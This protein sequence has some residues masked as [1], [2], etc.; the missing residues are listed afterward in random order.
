MSLRKTLILAVATAALAGPALA[1]TV[2]YIEVNSPPPTAPVEI[3]PAAREGYTWIP[4]YWSW[5]NGQYVWVQGV[6]VAS[7]PDYVWVPARWH[8][9]DG[10][11][12]Y[13]RGHWAHT[14]YDAEE[15]RDWQQQYHE[16]PEHIP[17]H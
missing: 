10:H 13:D 4:G 16:T 3:I 15:H 11:W 6:W 7:R 14:A 17:A 12:Y 1:Q 8:N 2:D 5:A 9:D